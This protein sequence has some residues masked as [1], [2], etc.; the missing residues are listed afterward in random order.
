MLEKVDLKN[1]IE[2]AEYKQR[3]PKLQERLRVLQ[4]ATFETGMPV[5]I[6]LEGWDASGKGTLVQRLLEKLDPRGF[7]VRPTYAATIDELYRP[8]LWRFWAKLPAFGEIAVFD[9]SWYGRVLV[10]R[11]EKL[12]T[13]DEL[14]SS[15]TEINEFERMI[16]D[17]GY[18]VVKLFLH[19]SKKEQKKRYRK[20]EKD[21]YL[22]W[23]VKPEDWRHHEQYDDYLEATEE[24]LEKTS[25]QHA[26][27]TIC[28]AN[29]RRWAEVE[30]F[31]AIIEAME[32]RL[33]VLNKLPSADAAGQLLRPKAL[34]E[35]AKTKR[36]ERRAPAAVAA[37]PS[38]R[39]S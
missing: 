24:M 25:S 26:P 29:D 12:I 10:E 3:M 8:F 32:Q 4:S 5:A 30:A 39:K 14:Q 9:R 20:C 38:G 35:L 2:K 37:G 18:V 6:V 17:G 28:E 31:G 27:W 33:K 34:P 11:V 21:A 7:K 23:K 22:R 15:F 36:R 16:T 19:I 1:K 13:P